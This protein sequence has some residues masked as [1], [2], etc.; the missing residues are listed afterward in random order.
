MSNVVRWSSSFPLI[1][2]KDFDSF[3]QDIFKETDPPFGSSEHPRYE[4]SMDKDGNKILKFALAGYP[5]KNIS[6]E[7]TVNKLKIKSD[8]VS[9]EDEN[10]H[11]IAR[12]AFTK[13]FYD[14]TGTWDLAATTAIY[15]D[16]LLIVTI[17]PR[18]ECK[19]KLI[20]IK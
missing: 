12:R 3:F 6:I 7:A 14:S 8:K 19:P 11:W 1:S 20:E 2:L 18:Q 17:P 4:E 9:D 5:R 13:E 16:G 15:E 10:K